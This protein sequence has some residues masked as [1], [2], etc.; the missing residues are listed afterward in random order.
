ML[1]AKKIRGNTRSE[2]ILVVE[3]DTNAAKLMEM[4]LKS[5][6]FTDIVFAK[7]G[8]EAWDHLK[9]GRHVNYD[10]VVSDLDMPFA[11][12][13]ELLEHIREMKIELPFVMVTGRGTIDAAIDA[14]EAEVTSFLMKPYSPQ[15]IRE[16]I[17]EALKGASKR[18]V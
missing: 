12:G 7:D 9:D 2:K 8:M 6:G 13:L 14:K 4:T 1:G 5:I 18:E 11:T 15:Q 3:D 10:L 16:R 17:L